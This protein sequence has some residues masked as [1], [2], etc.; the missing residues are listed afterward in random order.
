MLTNSIRERFLVDELQLGE[1][2][3]ASLQQGERAH[4]ALLL[5]M[6]SDDLLD[7]PP[8]SDSSTVAAFKEKDTKLRQYFSIGPPAPLDAKNA[9]IEE[10][11]FRSLLVHEGG[12]SAVRLFDAVIPEPLVCHQFELPANVWNELSPLKQAKIK[13]DLKVEHLPL[14]SLDEP[15]MLQILEEFDYEREFSVQYFF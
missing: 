1:A 9:S 14:D 7:S 12:T 3:N 10:T 8:F 5:S 2:L 6:L 11:E 13:D 15:S 4:F